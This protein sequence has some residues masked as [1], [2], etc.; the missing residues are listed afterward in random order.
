MAGLAVAGQAP[1]PGPG[2]PPRPPA[3]RRRV[4]ALQLGTLLLVVLGVAGESLAAAEVLLLDGAAH[5]LLARPRGRCPLLGVLAK[6]D[7]DDVALE[8][9]YL[10]A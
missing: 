4:G 9:H 10:S 7:N 5:V 2:G 6:V 8:I 3:P 1:V